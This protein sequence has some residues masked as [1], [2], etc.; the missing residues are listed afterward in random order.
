MNG[1]SAFIVVVVVILLYWLS[2]I[3]IRWLISWYGVHLDTVLSFG[4][5]VHP[6]GGYGELR[7]AHKGYAGLLLTRTV[8]SV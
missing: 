6:S 4:A 5:K 1:T 7:P 3:S 2:E 8:R